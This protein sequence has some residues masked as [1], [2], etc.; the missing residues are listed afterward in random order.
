MKQNENAVINIVKY[1][2]GFCPP[3]FRLMLFRNYAIH[4]TTNIP[5]KHGMNAYLY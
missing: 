4:L 2:L 3:F 1:W 5:E